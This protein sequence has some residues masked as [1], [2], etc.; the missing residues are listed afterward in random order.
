[1]KT[2]N[3]LAAGLSAV[4]LLLVA[5]PAQAYTLSYKPANYTLQTISNFA[6]FDWQ[7]AGT[8]VSPGFDPTV[9]VNLGIVTTYWASAVNLL[10]GAGMPVAAPGI[11]PPPLMPVGG[12]FTIKATIVENS[13]CL[14]FVGPNCMTSLFTAVSGS[15]D[16]YFDDVANANQVTG[17][18]ITDG[19]LLMSGTVNPGIA[20]SFTA[21]GVGGGS[22]VFSFVGPVGS[23][24]ITTGGPDEAYFGLLDVLDTSKASATLQWGDSTTGWVAPTGTPAAAG[25]TTPLGPIPP[26]TFLFQADGNQNFVP[27]PGTLALLGFGLLGMFGRAR[28]RKG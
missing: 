1:M 25:G 24:N 17:A 15:Y 16:I 2:M 13:V 18:G 4:G 20:G 11:Q 6:G 7:S 23:W 19:R 14:V 28:S 21:N 10:D 26:T 27:E 5:A 9:P 12:E 22:G 8:A 3:A